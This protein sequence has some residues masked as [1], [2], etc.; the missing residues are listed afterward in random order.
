MEDIRGRGD[1]KRREGKKVREKDERGL[2]QG[3][4]KEET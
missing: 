1:K 4:I 2:E 3:E